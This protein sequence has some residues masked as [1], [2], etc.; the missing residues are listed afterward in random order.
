M[1]VKKTVVMRDT[2]PKLYFKE[3]GQ[4]RSQDPPEQHLETIS[5]INPD[6]TFTE[7]Q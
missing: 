7:T 5:V 6:S 1:L 2:E 3:A 4:E